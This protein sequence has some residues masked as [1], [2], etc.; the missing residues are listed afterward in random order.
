MGIIHKTSRYV[1]FGSGEI[2]LTNELFYVIIFLVS[3]NVLYAEH[4]RGESEDGFELSCP[5]CGQGY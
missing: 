2:L 5:I 4:P 1:K 3:N